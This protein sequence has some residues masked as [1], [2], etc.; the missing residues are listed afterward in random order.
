MR[1]RRP[2]AGARR[3]GAELEGVAEF[4]VAVGDEDVAGTVH[5]Q[6]GWFSVD[7]RRTGGTPQPAEV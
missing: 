5:R 7:D 6:P 1:R 2:F 4:P 3:V